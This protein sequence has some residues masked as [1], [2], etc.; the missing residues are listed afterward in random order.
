MN[1]SLLHLFTHVS[2]LRGAACTALP[3]WLNSTSIVAGPSIDLRLFR[4]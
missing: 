1:G 2:P 4:R 3:A